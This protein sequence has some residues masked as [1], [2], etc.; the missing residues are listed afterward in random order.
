MGGLQN[1]PTPTDHPCGDDLVFFVQF[2]TVLL[3]RIYDV[4]F[5]VVIVAHSFDRNWANCARRL[6]W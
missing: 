5:I 3:Q 6:A 2:S 1:E 4:F